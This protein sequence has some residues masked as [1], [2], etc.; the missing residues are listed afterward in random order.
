MANKDPW[1]SLFRKLSGGN[2][3]VEFSRESRLVSLEPGGQK[4]ALVGNKR[5]STNRFLN[6][7]PD[8]NKNVKSLKQLHHNKEAVLNERLEIEKQIELD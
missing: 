7:S 3:E 2:E 4:K 6:K 5:I 8:F 1:H